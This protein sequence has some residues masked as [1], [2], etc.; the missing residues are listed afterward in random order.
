MGVQAEDE[1]SMNRRIGSDDYEKVLTARVAFEAALIVTGWDDARAAW[2]FYHQALLNQASS[3]SVRAARR[4]VDDAVIESGDE[5]LMD[6]KRRYDAAL[7]G[8]EL[9]A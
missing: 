3:E 4:W 8:S 1:Q 7:R 5:Q 9:T 6:A 2:H